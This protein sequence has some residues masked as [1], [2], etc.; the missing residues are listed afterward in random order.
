MRPAASNAAQTRSQLSIHW[1]AIYGALES[2]IRPGSSLRNGAAFTQVE[3]LRRVRVLKCYLCVRYK[4][5]P[6]CPEW[7]H[8]F[9]CARTDSNCRPP[10]SKLATLPTSEFDRL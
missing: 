6:I 7:T 8:L 3:A 5:L 1:V 4:P 9:L 2:S 10:D